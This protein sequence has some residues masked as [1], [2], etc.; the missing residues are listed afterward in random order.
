MALWS[1]LLDHADVG[2]HLVQLYGEDDQ[3]LARNVSRYMAEGLRRGD[4][5]V[6]IATF[7]HSAA[8][9]R[10]LGEECPEVSAGLE[11]G[12]L[13]FLDARATLDRFLVDGE[14]NRERFEQVV[15]GVLRVVRSHSS[16][17]RIRAFGEMVA[18]LWAEGRPDA[19]IRLEDYWNEL[20]RDG[21]FSLFCAYPFDILSRDANLEG[22]E[23][24]LHRHSHLCAGPGTTLTG[25]R[26]AS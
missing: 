6:M 12:R 2:E 3:L 26:A 1:D 25:T 7:E 17:G 16:T 23:A 22:L 8:V 10:Y 11:S 19:A 5:L 13:V 18:L 15:G 9:R 20:L 21:G 4:G 24:V 14:P